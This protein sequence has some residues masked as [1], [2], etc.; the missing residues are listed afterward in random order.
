MGRSTVPLFLKGQQKQDRNTP[1]VSQQC[2]VLKPDPGSSTSFGRLPL[3]HLPHLSQPRHGAVSAD[4]SIAER[5]CRETTVLPDDCGLS[6]RKIV[7]T[8]EGGTADRAMTKEKPLRPLPAEPLN[9]CT[10]L[11]FLREQLVR[12]PQLIKPGGSVS[13]NF[14]KME[15][16]HSD[17]LAIYNRVRAGGI[18]NF[19][20]TGL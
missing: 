12:S 20:R 10:L 13:K 3:C 19:L 7:L 8:H 18:V 2:G 17:N 4:V 11:R 6:T 15:R 1:L 16:N 9:E 14:F 5:L